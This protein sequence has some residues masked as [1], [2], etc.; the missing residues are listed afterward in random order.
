MVEAP[1]PEQL[2]EFCGVSPTAT[3]IS[4]VRAIWRGEPAR[5]GKDDELRA[6]VVR[7]VCLHPT[8]APAGQLG[9]LW[10]KGGKVTGELN[11]TGY[12]LDFAV[13]F[14]DTE[15]G[16]LVL[17]DTRVVALEILGGSCAGIAADR[18]DVAHDLVM[19]NGL[20]TTGPVQMPSAIIAGDL[21]FGGASLCPTGD[22]P[23]LL[24]DGARIGARVYMRS[25]GPKENKHPFRAKH[26]V[27]G[28][29][30]RI[31]GGVICANAHFEREV[32]FERAQ[33]QGEFSLFRAT[34]GKELNLDAAQIARDLTMNG[35]TINSPK[36]SMARARV[37]GTLTWEVLRTVGG[38]FEVDLTQAH[39][40]Y[41]NDDLSRWHNA[42]LTFEGVSFDGIKVEG[43]VRHLTSVR[44]WFDE[45]RKLHFVRKQIWLPEWVRKEDDS[46]LGARRRWLAS[47]K[48]DWSADPYDRTAAALARAGQAPTARAIAIEREVRRRKNSRLLDRP[49]S[50]LFGLLIGHGYRAL[51]AVGWALLGV[52]LAYATLPHAAKSYTPKADAPPFNAALYALDAFLPI[53]LKY[54]ANWTPNGDTA[55]YITAATIALGWLVAALLIAAVTGLIRRD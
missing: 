49:P 19:G 2:A 46:W 40:G 34:V 51:Y 23:S 38:D 50:W 14:E 35:T 29:N 37:G 48:G 45:G 36:V 7:A 25:S 15:L 33:V 13:R 27:Y 39:V 16:K 31:A 9:R 1:Q 43:T 6:C 47:Q 8:M 11:L 53:D 20:R 21:N 3:E 42:K 18:L 54:V 44:H 5:L 30:S 22:A 41:L 26:G 17:T 12:K 55:S 28:R 32:V 24:F 10:I 52:V 4:A